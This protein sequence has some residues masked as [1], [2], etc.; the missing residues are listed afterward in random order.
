[1]HVQLIVAPGNYLRPMSLV[2]H[3]G[4]SV[5]SDFSLAYGLSQ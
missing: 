5:V 3:F 1:M 2:G 4:G